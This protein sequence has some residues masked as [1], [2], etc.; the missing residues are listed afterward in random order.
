ALA[1]Q[2]FAS[3]KTNNMHKLAKQWFKVIDP[4]LKRH[5]IPEDFRYIPFVES[6]FRQGTSSKGAEGFWQ[7]M[8]ET[9]MQFGLRVDEEVDERLDVV[10]ST[11]AACR[12]LKT[13][14]KEFGNW[15]LV[16]A[17][18]NVGEGSLLRTMNAQDNDDYYSLTLNRETS[19]YVYKL[20]AAKEIITRPAEFGYTIK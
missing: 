4:I 11:H 17:A 9:A 12:Y 7:F 18:Y 2:N 10:K 5:G 1:K 16:A 13:L 8:P 14:Y 19:Q 15:T 6:K 3:T 20:L